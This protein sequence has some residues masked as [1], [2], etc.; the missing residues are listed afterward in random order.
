MNKT[1]NQIS[2]NITFESFQF[3][4]SKAINLSKS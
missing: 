1:I 4:K 3:N 2:L